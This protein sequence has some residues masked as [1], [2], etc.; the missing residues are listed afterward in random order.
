MININY[1]NNGD[2]NAV[3]FPNNVKGNRESLKFLETLRNER[4]NHGWYYNLK[5]IEKLEYKVK[6][7]QGKTKIK[8]EVELNALKKDREDLLNILGIDGPPPQLKIEI[9][10][11]VI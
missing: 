5:K 10:K 8:L 11:T 4:L 3:T 6:W 2:L 1:S 9:F 7:S